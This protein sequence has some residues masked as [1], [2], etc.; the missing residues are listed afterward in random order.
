[1]KHLILIAFFGSLLYNYTLFVIAKSNCDKGGVDFEYKKYFKM[2]WDNWGL[3]IMLVPVLVWFLPDIIAVFN[4]RFS[5]KLIFHDVYYLSAGP[6]T[7][8]FLFGMFKLAGWKD[9]WIA[10]VHK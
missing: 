5:V 9:T 6:L 1:M 7:E 2:N 10:P 4:E 3:T 8:L